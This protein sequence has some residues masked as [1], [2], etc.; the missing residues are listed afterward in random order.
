MSART[1]FL[2]SIR[3]EVAEYRSVYIAPLVIAAFALAGFVYAVAKH[4]IKPLY[5]LDP[6]M[7]AQAMAI[8]YSMAA[9]VILLTGWLVGIMYASDAL[10]GERRDRSILFWKSLPVSD[11]VTVA[12]KAAIPLLAIPA[13]CIAVAIVTQLVMLVL[14]SAMLAAAGGDPALPWKVWPMGRQTIVMLYG[15]AIHI[16]WF[17][18]IYAWLLLVSAWAKRAVL[19]W[20]FVPLLGLFAIEKVSLNTSWLMSAIQ[21]RILGAMTEGFAR[22][23]LRRPITEFSQLDPV[24]FFSNP[25]LWLGLA[26]AGLCFALAVR[27][28]RYGEPI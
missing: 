19:L 12:S 2:W 21:Y 10:H 14:G 1:A 20:A 3:R 28:R 17:A 22:D 9:S 6:A 11:L 4:G 18:P 27:L 8:P 25:N 26:F 24:R 23:A 13:I 5:A 16:L 15:M 7:Q